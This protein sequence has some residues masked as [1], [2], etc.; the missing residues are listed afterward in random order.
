MEC[1]EWGCIVL[2]GIWLKYVWLASGEETALWLRFAIWFLNKTIRLSFFGISL[3]YLVSNVIKPAVKLLQNR[4]ALFCSVLFAFLLFAAKLYL[5]PII[6]W[7]STSLVRS[8]FDNLV[9]AHFYQR[10]E[11]SLWKHSLGDYQ[12][13]CQICHFCHPSHHAG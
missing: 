8:S 2:A 7:S 1:T 9:L 13:Q 4:Y 6:T 3:S 11:F 10:F 5:K 12:F